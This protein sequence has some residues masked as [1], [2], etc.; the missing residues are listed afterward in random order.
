M[1]IV[2]GIC[3]GLVI[4]SREDDVID[5][6]VGACIAVGA[7]LAIPH[8]IWRLWGK[9]VIGFGIR[10][11]AYEGLRFICSVLIVF[12]IVIFRLPFATAV[13]S[14]VLGGIS[15]KNR[16]TLFTS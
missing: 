8:I 11:G 14:Y 1:S 13:G 9:A 15:S 2:G 4:A 16:N 10:L 3:A 5:T 7:A 12:T 6:P